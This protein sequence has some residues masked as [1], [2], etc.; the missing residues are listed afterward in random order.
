MTTRMT[1]TR[2][3]EIGTHGGCGLVVAEIVRRLGGTPLLRYDRDEP[4]V[5]VHAAVRLD[6]Q[7]VHLGDDD[8]RFVEVSIEEFRRACEEDFMPDRCNLS[9]DEIEEVVDLMFPDSVEER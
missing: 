8:E 7:L 9:E 5:A 6:G 4:E 1:W 2:A 3:K